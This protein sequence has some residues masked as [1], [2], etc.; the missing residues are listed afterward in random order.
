MRTNIGVSVLAQPLVV[1]MHL[2]VWQGFCD[3]NIPLLYVDVSLNQ[4]C[5]WNAEMQTKYLSLQESCIN[6]VNN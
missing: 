3:V 2:Y 4:K 6:G 1:Y 5:E